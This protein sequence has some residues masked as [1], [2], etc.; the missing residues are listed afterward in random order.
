MILNSRFMENELPVYTDLTIKASANISLKRYFKSLQRNLPKD[1]TLNK[2]K[3]Q[4]DYSIF[5][6]PVDII[7]LETPKFCG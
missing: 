4:S 5:E 7:C 6:I 3:A 2:E 1:W